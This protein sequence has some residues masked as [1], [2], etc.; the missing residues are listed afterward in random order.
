MFVQLLSGNSIYTYK[1]GNRCLTFIFL[2][3]VYELA[4][5]N[6]LIEETG[7]AVGLQGAVYEGLKIGLFSYAFVMASCY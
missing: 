7:S 2:C 5:P 6:D 1:T 3:V 4:E